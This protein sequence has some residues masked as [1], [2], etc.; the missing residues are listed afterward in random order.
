MQDTAA[1]VESD[2]IN[3]SKL[4]RQKSATVDPAFLT[5][6]KDALDW[7]L[8][9]QALALFWG[10]AKWTPFTWLRFETLQ[11]SSPLTM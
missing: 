6:W 4:S 3:E 11:E 1:A 5:H 2:K 8:L 9:E 7:L 10:V